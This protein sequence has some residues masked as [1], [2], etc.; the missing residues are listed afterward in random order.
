MKFATLAALVASAS[1]VRL[2]QKRPSLV[3]LLAVEEEEWKCPTQEQFDE[4]SAWVHNEL[5]TGDKT[6]T[7]QEATDGMNSFCEAH[8]IDP[9]DEM[10]E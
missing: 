5:T 2:F 3:E 7:L 1:A 9:T 8:G 10:K 4:I 6:I